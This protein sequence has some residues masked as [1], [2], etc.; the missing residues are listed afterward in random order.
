MGQFRNSTKKHRQPPMTLRTA[1]AFSPQ[2]FPSGG[3]L[4]LV[5][6]GFAS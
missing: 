1:K 5:V 6:K 3:F 2:E 4:P